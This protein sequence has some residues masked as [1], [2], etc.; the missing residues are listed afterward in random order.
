MT[1]LEIIGQMN[2]RFKNCEGTNM[3]HI[4]AILCAIGW[5]EWEWEFESEEEA[6]YAETLSF[7]EDYLPARAI[8]K[9]C[10][11]RVNPKNCDET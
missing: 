5:H 6:W 2:L 10:G 4:R 9:Y 1:Q 3:K 11:K 8:C 7:P